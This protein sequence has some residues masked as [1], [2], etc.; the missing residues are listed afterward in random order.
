MFIKYRNSEEF[1]PIDD[2]KFITLER[3]R[4]VGKNIPLDTVGFD[5]YADDEEK[6]QIYLNGEHTVLY[7]QTEEYVEFTTDTNIYNVFCIY[8]PE[9]MYVTGQISSTSTEDVNGVLIKSG[10]GK[11]FQYPE[12]VYQYVDANGFFNYKIDSVETLNIVEVSD[13]EKQL[14]LEEKKQHEF[15]AALGSK[16]D[17]LSRTCNKHIDEGMDYNGVHFSYTLE[18]QTNIKNAL[19][20]SAATGLAC[21]YHADGC[22]CQLFTKEDIT[23]IYLINQTNL[24]HHST[25][26]NQL[27]LYTQS[28]ETVEAVEA[29]A[30]GQDLEGEY[31]ETYNAIMTQSKK[32]IAAYLGVEESAVDEILGVSSLANL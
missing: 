21:P 7:E 20:L 8:N 17:E 18:D 4:L 22:S 14:L 6:T 19:E 2:Y 5:V 29:V 10:Q 3:V 12:S 9:T 15:N 13:E 26:F 32:I 25:Y 23:S 27:K 1:H 30:Y 28:L 24:T 11:E 16:L 31:L